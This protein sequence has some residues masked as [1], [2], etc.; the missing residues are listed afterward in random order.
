MI[1]IYEIDKTFHHT[2]AAPCFEK[3]SNCYKAINE[4]ERAIDLMVKAAEYHVQ[5]FQSNY[6]NCV[7]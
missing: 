4:N 1:V 2:G 3:A 6:D 7:T 5:V